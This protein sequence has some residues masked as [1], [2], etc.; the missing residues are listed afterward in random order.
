MVRNGTRRCDLCCSEILGHGG[1]DICVVCRIVMEDDADADMREC[2][3]ASLAELEGFALTGVVGRTVGLDQAQAAND[4]RLTRRPP[5]R[6]R[7]RRPAGKFSVP[8]GVVRF[9]E[10][11][12]AIS[13]RRLGG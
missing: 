10:S 11:L 4:E 6:A 2:S 8:Q 3:V 1:S 7:R 12:R 13:K 9:A 5:H